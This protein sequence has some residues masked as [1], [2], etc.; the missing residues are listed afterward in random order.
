MTQL[1]T[2]HTWDNLLAQ[3]KQ[4]PYF[5][6]MESYLNQQAADGV[7]LYPA[8]HERFN[9]FQ[10]TS[11]SS[12]KVV[13]IGQDPYHGPGQAHGLSFSVQSGT[14]LPPSLR[15]V[16]KALKADLA[17]PPAKE[18]D[19]T[20][21]AQ[22]G[23]LLLN[24]ALSVEAHH[25][26]SHTHIGWQTFTDAA[27]DYLNHHPKPILFLLWGKHAQKK[28]QIITNTHHHALMAPHPSPLSAHRGFLTCQHF[29]QAN[30]W[31]V[32]QGH[33]PIEWELPQST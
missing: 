20:A 21:W 4:K 9:A 33:T 11:F 15:N 28:A 22:Q 23:V 32:R 17:I 2:T 8:A 27:I 30:D 24:T 5:Q 18:G 3:E 16:F 6:T 31:L 10:L 29:S 13:L 14:P 26:G 25:A 12:V 1:T 7:T 19:L